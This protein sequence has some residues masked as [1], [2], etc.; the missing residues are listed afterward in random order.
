M[1]E[2]DRLVSYYVVISFSLSSALLS[3]APTQPLLFI[4]LTNKNDLFIEREAE[5]ATYPV[6]LTYY[7]M[8]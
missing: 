2:F 6:L 8:L 4:T 5:A 1:I 7:L 3:H